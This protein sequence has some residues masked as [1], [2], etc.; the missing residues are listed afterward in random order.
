MHVLYQN[1][2]SSGEVPAS[3][4][5]YALL[6]HLIR[7]RQRE[8]ER[9]A[10]TQFC[11]CPDTAAIPFYEAL[12]DGKAKASAGIFVFVKAL[13]QTEDSASLFLVKPNTVILNAYNPLVQVI[14]SNDVNP[15]RFSVFSI[16]QSIR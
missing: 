9:S 1:C 8:P 14:L 15:W 5:F 12:T 10:F 13:E 2:G 16:F 6:S 3:W 4:H 7:L 11:L